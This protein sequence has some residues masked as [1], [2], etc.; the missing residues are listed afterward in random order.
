[1]VSLQL[2]MVSSQFG[3]APPAGIGSLKWAL[4]ARLAQHL[5]EQR[6]PRAVGLAFFI[7]LFCVAY[8][9]TKHFINTSLRRVRLVLF[10]ATLH[11]HNFLL[12]LPNFPE[13]NKCG[14]AVRNRL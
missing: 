11:T 12:A 3:R 14:A 4:L 8:Q 10:G 6:H 13:P 5:G 2:C 9:I 7:F 1:M